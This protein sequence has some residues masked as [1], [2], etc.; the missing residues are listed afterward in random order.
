M[1]TGQ[2]VV[3]Q[4][5]THRDKPWRHQGRGHAMDCAGLV[6]KTAH[7]LGLTE[8]DNTNYP[9]RPDGS[10]MRYFV[11]GGCIR[12]PL[13]DAEDGDVLVFA[14]RGLACH[15]GIRTTYHGRPAV[16]HAHRTRGKVIEEPLDQSRA[17]V[18]RPTAAF[19]LPGVEG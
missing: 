5:R 19:R 4:A 7:E 9:R 15:C 1:T 17:V 10:F 8:Y 2:D 18:G 16:I 13:G 6:A 12:V 3:A 14:E 11:E